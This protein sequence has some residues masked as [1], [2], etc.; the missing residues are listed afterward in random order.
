[1]PRQIPRLSFSNPE[2]FEYPFASIR[3]IASSWSRLLAP[4]DAFFEL[5]L[6]G[7]SNGGIAE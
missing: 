2:I 1:M 7:N 3:D 4:S 6:L 5:V